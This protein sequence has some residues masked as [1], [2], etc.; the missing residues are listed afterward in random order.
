LIWVTR[1][2]AINLGDETLI[3]CRAT[4]EM[5]VGSTCEYYYAQVKN[6]RLCLLEM[7]IR[8]LFIFAPFRVIGGID[9]RKI[10]AHQCRDGIV[11][12][13]R[14]K[15]ELCVIEH[16]VHIKLYGVE[17]LSCGNLTGGSPVHIHTHYLKFFQLTLVTYNHHNEWLKWNHTT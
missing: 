16:V 17:S 14:Y 5:W 1:W 3:W 11:V 8:C 7:V 12:D 4:V 2:L 6:N 13:K 10:N 9:E 15:L